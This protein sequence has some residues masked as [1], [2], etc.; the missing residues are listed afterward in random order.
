MFGAV[1]VFEMKLKLFWKQL[2]NVNLCHFNSCYL[3]QKDGS[4]GF[5]LP[6]VR[7]VEM[8]GSILK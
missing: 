6:S 4:V 2:Q 7:A 3:F 5:R 1:R 8:I